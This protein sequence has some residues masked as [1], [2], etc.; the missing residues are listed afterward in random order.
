MITCTK[1][2]WIWK[3]IIYTSYEMLFVN[4]KVKQS[5]YRPGQ[6]WEFQEVDAPKFKDIWHMNVV[7]LS[8]LSTSRFYSQ[9][10]F[11]V[12]ISV[13]GWVNLRTILRKEGLCQWKIPMTPTRNRTRDL[14]ACRSIVE[15]YLNQLRYR[16]K[17]L[18]VC[19][20]EESEK[21]ESCSTHGWHNGY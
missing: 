20:I 3:V 14:P 13:R 16:D 1:C 12:S 19:E 2:C 6:P 5:H 21:G 18:L 11:L 9:E 17:M 8:A 7:R 15:Q 10:I 4:V